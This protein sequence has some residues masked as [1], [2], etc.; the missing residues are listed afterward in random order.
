ME[1]HHNLRAGF[2]EIAKTADRYAVIDAN[3]TIESLHDEIVK[4]VRERL[5]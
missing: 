2:L 1:F 5:L 3:K 4:L